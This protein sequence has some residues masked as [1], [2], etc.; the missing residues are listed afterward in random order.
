MSESSEESVGYGLKPIVDRKKQL[1]E[2]FKKQAKEFFAGHSAAE[3][4]KLHQQITEGLINYVNGQFSAAERNSAKIGIYQPMK[5]ELPVK[6]IVNNSEAFKN[7]VY[8]FPQVDGEKMWFT[9]E[10]GANAEPE[11]IIV[12]GLFVDRAG[13]RL[14]RGKGYYDRYLAA[15]GLALPRR[16]FLGYAFQFIEAVPTTGLDQPV[17]PV[18]QSV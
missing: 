18:P 17:T 12:P 5:V 2:H 8:V 3:L 1:R 6:D 4:S 14:G 13:N 9:D 7:P 10:G 11:I 16:I 15:S